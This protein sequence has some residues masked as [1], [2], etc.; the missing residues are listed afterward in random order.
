MHIQCLAACLFSFLY[1]IIQL[2]LSPELNIIPW[3]SSATA[4]AYMFLNGYVSLELLELKNYSPFKKYFRIIWRLSY[5]SYP[6][7]VGFHL[8]LQLYSCH[9]FLMHCTRYIYIYT[10]YMCQWMSI[11]LFFCLKVL[12]WLQVCALPLKGKNKS[13]EL[14]V[15]HLLFLAEETALICESI[16]L[17]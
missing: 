2:H 10:L 7:V 17:I 12:C 14:W 4:V 15:W 3:W 1:K 6:F 8:H 16:E 13:S 5:C 9:Y 11:Y